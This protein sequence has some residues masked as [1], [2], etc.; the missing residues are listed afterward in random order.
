MQ[1]PAMSSD[2]DDAEVCPL[3]RPRTRSPC[4][5]Q[6]APSWAPRRASSAA[7]SLFTGLRARRVGRGGCGT[8]V[9]LGDPLPPRQHPDSASFALQRPPTAAAPPGAS[10]T[11]P[12]PPPRSPPQFW[13]AGGEEGSG[14]RRW[15][16]AGG[17][18][19]VGPG[20]GRGC[21]RCA[22]GQLV[23]HLNSSQL[24]QTQVQKRA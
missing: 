6:T 4:P 12:R 21:P 9:A 19:G 16:G 11:P 2:E 8:P 15:R 13:G 18:A 22:G 7:S 23:C 20:A 24:R 14:G 5:W 1:P 3:S 17:G 10:A